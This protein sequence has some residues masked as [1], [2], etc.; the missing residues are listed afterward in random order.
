[1]NFGDLTRVIVNVWKQ[2]KNSK[3]LGICFGKGN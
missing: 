1:M 3:E 2:Q